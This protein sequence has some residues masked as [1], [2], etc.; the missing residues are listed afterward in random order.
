MMAFMEAAWCTRYGP[1]EVLRAEE[2]AKP[3]PGPDE[4]WRYVGE[5]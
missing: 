3:S 1:P 2:V 4:V 5:T